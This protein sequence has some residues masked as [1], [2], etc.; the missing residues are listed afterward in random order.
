VE[1]FDQGPGFSE[2]PS[3]LMS[4]FKGEGRHASN[5]GLGLAIVKG[6]AENHQAVFELENM[7]NGGALCRLRFSSV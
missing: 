1:V 7:E 2:D 3:I 6:V 5:V 4:A